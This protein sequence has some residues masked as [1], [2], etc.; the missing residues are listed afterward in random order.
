MV[1]SWVYWAHSGLASL[2]I[3]LYVGYLAEQLCGRDARFLPLTLVWTRSCVQLDKVLRSVVY[4]CQVLYWT[5]C[6][7]RL[8]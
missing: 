3:R 6:Y 4:M 1:A 7:V 5:R 8:G 2:T